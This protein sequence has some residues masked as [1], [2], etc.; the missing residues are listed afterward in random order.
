VAPLV[1]QGVVG[2]GEEVDDRQQA[3]VIVPSPLEPK[4]TTALAGCHV[5]W[6]PRSAAVTGSPEVGST[7]RTSVSRPSIA[8]MPSASTAQL[9]ETVGP[10]CTLT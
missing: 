9:A 8:P 10:P 2:A 5:H 3:S 1:C 4:N 6:P 7:E